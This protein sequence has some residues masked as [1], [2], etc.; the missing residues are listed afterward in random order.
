L[1]DSDFDETK[2]LEYNE[3]ITTYDENKWKDLGIKYIY[4]ELHEERGKLESET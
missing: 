2:V 1:D 3:Y 4:E